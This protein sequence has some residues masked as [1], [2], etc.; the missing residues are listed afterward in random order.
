MR[1]RDSDA[2]LDDIC[3][4]FGTTRKDV[5]ARLADAGFVYDEAVRR[6]W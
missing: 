5:E 4:S 2:D 3:A 6:F 1:L